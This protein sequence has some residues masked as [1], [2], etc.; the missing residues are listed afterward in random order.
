MILE[1]IAG[2]APYMFIA[3]AAYIAGRIHGS[4][5]VIDLILGRKK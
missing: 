5:G 2:T 1:L 4:M 3:A